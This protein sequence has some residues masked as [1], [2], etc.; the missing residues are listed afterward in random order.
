ML[1]TFRFVVVKT[2][3]HL[4]PTSNF[5]SLSWSSWAVQADLFTQLMAV[6]DRVCWRIGLAFCCQRSSFWNVRVVVEV[7]EEEHHGPRVVECDRVEEPRVIT[8]RSHKLVVT[9]VTD[10][11][12][13]LDLKLFCAWKYWDIHWTSD[14]CSSVKD[15][16]WFYTDY[17]W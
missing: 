2:V 11:Q 4:F 1:M 7:E 9:G 16:K 10:D 5:M 8:V 14:M 13:K 3:R 12:H 6:V 17:G 15:S